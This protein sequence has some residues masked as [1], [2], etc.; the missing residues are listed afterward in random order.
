MSSPIV[1]VDTSQIRPGRLAELQAAMREL[2]AFVEANEPR[3]IAYHVYF[4]EAGTRMTVLHID[5]DP[6]ALAFHMRTA[7]PKFPPIGE[8]ID[9]LSIDVYGE[10]SDALAEQ[11]R[12]KA[13]L[14]G[15]GVVR[16]HQLHSGF[17]RLPDATR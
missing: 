8:F 6:E 7:G 12:H 15:R 4:D 16:M 2:A 13:E 9:L 17:T 10:V 3:L 14:L 5:P 1:Y 11:L